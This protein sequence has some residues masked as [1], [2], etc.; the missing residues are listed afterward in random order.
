MN[1]TEILAE[2]LR[3][4]VPAFLVFSNVDPAREWNGTP[5]IEFMETDAETKKYISGQT[6][7]A[8]NVSMAV[9][10]ETEETASE[11]G[12]SLKADVG[13]A[14]DWLAERQEIQTW[15]FEEE[16]TTPDARGVAS[17]ESFYWYLDIRILENL[18][19]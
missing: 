2:Y 9:R 17:G 3:P 10:A 6:Q 12:R 4:R 19:L 16:G 18:I 14:L 13:D 7:R 8:V 5:T 11:I 1:Y 15:T